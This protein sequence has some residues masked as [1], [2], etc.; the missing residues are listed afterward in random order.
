MATEEQIPPEPHLMESMRAVGYTLEAAIADLVD[1][2]ITAGASRIDISFASEP[3]D[4][5]AVLDNGS[6]MSRQAAREAMRLAARSSTEQRPA[7]DLGRFGLG[8]KTA[9]LS[10]CRDITLVSKTSEGVVAYS[11]NLD[12][13]LREGTWSLLRLDDVEVESLPGVERLL[14][15]ESGTLVLWRELDQL[16][17]HAGETA[18]DMDSAMLGVRD[19]LGLIFHRF[20]GDSRRALV[21]R[22][23]S[24]AIPAI[25]P[26]LSTHRRTQRLP[27][28][29]FKVEGSTVTVQPFTVPRLTTLSA[30][31]RA[32]LQVAG[33]LRDSQGFYIYRA[34][35]LVIWGTWFRILPRQDMAKLSRVQ[36]DVP[37][38]LDH[39]WALDIKKAT[40]Q[41]PPEV[42]RRLKKFADRVTTPSK[43]TLNWQGRKE[44]SATQHVW[45]LVTHENGFTYSLNRSH[46]AVDAALVASGGQGEAELGRLLTLIEATMPGDDIFNRLAKD[47]VME[48]GLEESAIAEIARDMWTKYSAAA[49]PAATKDAFVAAMI[50]VE[51]FSGHPRGADILKEAV[52]G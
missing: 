1:N 43:N 47:Q 8:L 25:D 29:S 28:E 6:G 18:A 44:K 33:Q 12:H 31:D 19:H 38:S 22:L 13:L 50:N 39:L 15:L 30:A 5:V 35:R 42:R 23:N 46:P 3:G 11:W 34:R 2:S 21:I 32:S 16:R 17:A 7:D 36:V 40:A 24:R 48:N 52:R 37:N 4:F 10:Q 41:P 20:I 49:G 27:S 26:F 14:A 45:Q 51:P 9:S